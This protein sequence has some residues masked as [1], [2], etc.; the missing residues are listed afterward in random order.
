MQDG[1]DRGSFLPNDLSN[2]EHLLYF[3]DISEEEGVLGNMLNM[4]AKDVAVDCHG[5]LTVDTSDVQHKRKK[6]VQEETEQNERKT[7]RESI[8]NSM[9]SIAVTQ[10][11]ENLRV[12]LETAAKCEVKALAEQNERVKE[13][14]ERLQRD[15]E[16]L[17]S[18]IRAEID[19]FTSSRARAKDPDN[20][21]DAADT[22][23]RSK[24]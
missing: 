22:N 14:Y 1:D 16:A 24:H 4:L 2:R 8:G 17:A 15:Q 23:K 9:K 13:V 18:D 21:K 6:T 11:K 10:L 20:D 5:N 19:A 3:W 12:T 7:F